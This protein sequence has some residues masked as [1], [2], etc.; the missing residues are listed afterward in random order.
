MYQTLDILEEAAPERFR[1]VLQICLNDQTSGSVLVI[2]SS[3]G[4]TE[5]SSIANIAID[6][7]RKTGKTLLISLMGEDSN[8]QEARRMLHR[9]GIPAFRTP[10]EAV[11]AFMNMYTYTR[12]LESLYQTQKKSN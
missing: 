7:P 9:N 1:N 3:Q 2:Y 12:N 6:L 8:C 11:I 10:E 4:V 5:P